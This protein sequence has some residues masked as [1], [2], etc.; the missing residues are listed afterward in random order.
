MVHA[1]LGSVSLPDSPSKSNP[2]LWG[3]S[4]KIDRDFVTSG[5]IMTNSLNGPRHAT[6]TKEIRLHGQLM[7]LGLPCSWVQQAVVLGLV[8]PGFS[9]SKV[10]VAKPGLGIG[11][12][13]MGGPTWPGASSVSG[14]ASRTPS[15]IKS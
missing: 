5:P 7:G 2:Y 6:S 11:G 1:G 12:E 14:Q 13:R 3:A 10:R 4:A 15:P 9:P 8:I